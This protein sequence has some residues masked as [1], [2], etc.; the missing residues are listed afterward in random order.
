MNKNRSKFQ[1][2]FSVIELMVSILLF[3]VVATSIVT[4][5]ADSFGRLGVETRASLST[6]ELKNALG[7]L[8]SELRMT[9]AISPYNV[10]IDATAV[11]CGNRLTA[12]SNTLYFF[13][14]YDDS[15][16]SSGTQNYYVGYQ[17]SPSENILYRG[18]VTSGSSNCNIPVADPL[19]S[20]N[21]KILA[22]DVIQIDANNDGVL[23]NVFTKNSNQILV[24][25]GVRVTG[26]RGITVTQNLVTTVF[27][28]AI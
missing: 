15:S 2:G 18:E 7:L 9:G 6:R 14:S 16:V 3:S 1:L 10:G 8:Q 19:S 23:D 12:T 22:K 5:M 4:F 21:K 11:T 13:V 26:P 20:A 28:R 25:I 24:N 17:F 27:A